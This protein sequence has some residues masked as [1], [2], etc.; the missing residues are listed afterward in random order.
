[1]GAQQNL[2]QK[3][4][5]LKQKQTPELITLN[6]LFYDVGWSTR[7]SKYDDGLQQIVP[8]ANQFETIHRHCALTQLVPVSPVPLESPNAALLPR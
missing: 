5:K 8:A 6:N 7:V 2:N 4:T 3:S 1:M